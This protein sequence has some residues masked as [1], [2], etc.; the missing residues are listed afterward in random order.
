MTSVILYKVD[1][2][3]GKNPLVEDL[4]TYLAAVP[5]VLEFDDFQY[6]KN[7]LDISIKIVS[8]QKLVNNFPYNYVKIQNEGEVP[9]YYYIIDTS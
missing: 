3:M 9:Y 8:D 6:V 1:F 5:T 4:N 7:D 2:K